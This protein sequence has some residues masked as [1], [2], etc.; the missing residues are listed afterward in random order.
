[1]IKLKV[2]LCNGKLSLVEACTRGFYSVGKHRVLCH[3]LV[4]LLRQ[5]NRAFDNVS[6]NFSSP[7]IVI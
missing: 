4:D 2:K 7:A 5:L 6:S 1:M 3:N